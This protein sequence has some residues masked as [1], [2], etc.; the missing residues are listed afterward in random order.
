MLP[1]DHRQPGSRSPTTVVDIHDG[2][3]IERVDQVATEEPLEIRVATAGVKRTLSVTMRT[4]GADFELAA[5]FLLSEGVV[6]QRDD[7]R[8]IRYCTDPDVDG[9]QRYNVVT[10]DLAPGVT[11]DMDRL[12]RHVITNSSCGVCG[13]GAL[14]SIHRQGRRH[15]SP[16][17]V[18]DPDL[19]VELPEHLRSAQGV[20]DSTGGLHATGLFTPDGGLVVAREDVGR[21]NAVDKVV[22]WALLQGR[23][24]LADHLL[25]VS[26]RTS[27]EIVQKAIAA[28][29]P[30]ICAISAPSSL[31]VD[32]AREFGITLIGFLRDRRFNVYAGEYRV[33]SA[34]Y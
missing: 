5:G 4:P 23:L 25:M 13:K 26:G 19:I 27:F 7:I 15:L 10:V 29:V 11:I 16:G 17:L 1:G 22:G 31:A 24:P 28:G 9:D 14:E 34:E 32:L 33:R 12:E 21:H 8:R 30:M 18:V 2:T 6:E 20:F 3:R